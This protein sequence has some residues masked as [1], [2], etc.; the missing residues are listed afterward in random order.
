M[1]F[2]LDTSHMTGQGH[3]KA[4]PSGKR[5][6]PEQRLVLGVPNQHRIAAQKLR[7]ALVEIGVEEICI[8]CKLTEWMGHPMP[9]E[10]DHI[11][12]QYWDNRPEN[13]QIVCP[14]CHTLKTMG[15]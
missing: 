12:G 15:Y 9:L 6:L 3:N 2:G 14:N 4:K 5:L 13:L 7:K 8:K 11:N 1:K 10:V